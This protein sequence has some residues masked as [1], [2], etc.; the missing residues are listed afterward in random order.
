[1]FVFWVGSTATTAMLVFAML[2]V[3]V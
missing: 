3:M 1:M 2:K